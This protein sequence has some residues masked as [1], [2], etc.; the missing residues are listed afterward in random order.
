MDVND[1]TRAC[2]RP[3]LMSGGQL[4][5]GA[6]QLGGAGVGRIELQNTGDGF[7]RDLRIALWG[8]EVCS[9]RYAFSR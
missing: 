4:L 9:R 1:G 7:H 5:S 3:H 6:A 2:S 8:V